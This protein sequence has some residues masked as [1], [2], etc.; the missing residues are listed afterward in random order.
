MTFDPTDSGRMVGYSLCGLAIES[1]DW[2]TGAN[3]HITSNQ[4]GGPETGV[5]EA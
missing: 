5:L 2:I 3:G 1:P 4:A